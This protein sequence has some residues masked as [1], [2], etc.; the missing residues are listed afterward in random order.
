LS[1]LFVWKGEEGR[2]WAI[3]YGREEKQLGAGTKTGKIGKS[4]IRI[5][6]SEINSLCSFLS[7]S[8]EMMV[9]VVRF[10]GIKVR[11]NEC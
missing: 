9:L 11:E 1:G 5:A 2:L 8:G 3:G 7:I 10:H 4:E 6:K